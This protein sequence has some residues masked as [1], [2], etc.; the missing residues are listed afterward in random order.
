MKSAGRVWTPYEDA[1]IRVLASSGTS[2]AEIAEQIKRSESAVRK[3][4]ARLRIVVA[5]QKAKK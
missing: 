5:K 3:R 2:A 1:R 4:A